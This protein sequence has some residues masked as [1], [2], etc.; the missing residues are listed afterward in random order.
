MERPYFDS[1][2]EA[3]GVSDLM[4][5][6]GDL[7]CSHMS[8]A[9]GEQLF[10]TCVRVDLW[11]LLEYNQPWGAQAFE[12]SDL[13][14]TAKDW[15]SH[16]LETIPNSRLHFIKQRSVLE[17]H[18]IVFYVA[19][20]HETHPAMFRFHLDSYDELTTLDASA[21]LAGELT[22]ATDE[23]LLLVCTNGRRDCCCALHGT[24]VYNACVRRLGD[25]ISIWQ[26]TH[27]GGHRR[28]DHAVLRTA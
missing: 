5:D 25:G 17:T 3:A 20:A 6:S 16:Q 4:S 11:L 15:L 13:P 21:I 2:R 8:R 14:D 12:E 28:R 22:K 19:S 18:D 26:T 27:S 24:S 1:R 9:V 10:G 23:K 7:F